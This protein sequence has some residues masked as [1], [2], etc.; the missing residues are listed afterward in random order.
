MENNFEPILKGIEAIIPIE[1]VESSIADL[2]TN[3][4][5]SQGEF[6]LPGGK[7]VISI[8]GYDDP[9]DV[10]VHSSPTYQR[11]NKRFSNFSGGGV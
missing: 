1:A 6:L 10:T 2:T 4:F 3:G 11:E 8:L 9:A 7:A 5:L